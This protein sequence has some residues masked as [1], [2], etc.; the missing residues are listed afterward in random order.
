VGVEYR[1]ISAEPRFFS[2][3]SP[4]VFFNTSEALVPRD[5]NG[6]ADAYEYNSNTGEVSLLSSGMGEDG[7]WFVDASADG[8]DV[9]LAT[10]Q[11]LSPWD[12]DK[13]V[14]LY[15][16]RAGGG[17]PGPPA[18]KPPCVGDACQGIPSAA[19]SFNVASAFS[20]VGNVS[21]AGSTRTR[22]KTLTAAQKLRRALAACA[23]RRA[24]RRHR[25]D[26]A[27]HRRYGVHSKKAKPVGR[28]F[29][30][31]RKG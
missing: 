2:G 26:A 1:Q 9:F 4:Y 13:L 24:S 20:G 23:R 11:K 10:R 21:V 5:T 12:P 29:R 28:S 3:N 8:R 25:C 22:R 31:A 18:A 14:D 15:D 19:P 17:L 30:L 6:V 16:A 27:A 7:T